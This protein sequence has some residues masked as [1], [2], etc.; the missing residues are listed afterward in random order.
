MPGLRPFRVITRVAATALAVL[1]L[2]SLPQSTPAFA[3]SA[4]CQYI[5]G[6][7]TLHHLIPDTVGACEE[8]EGHNPANGDG[9]QHTAGGCWSGARATTGLHSPMGTGPG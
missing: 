9:L 6:F 5:L 7:K 8:N 3:Q 2:L 4:T 1:V